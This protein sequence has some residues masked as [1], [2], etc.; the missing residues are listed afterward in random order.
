MGNPGHEVQSYDPCNTLNDSSLRQI[1]FSDY[2]DLDVIL[3]AAPAGWA[4]VDVS[5]AGT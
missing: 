1:F 4:A 2:I 3:A 5:A